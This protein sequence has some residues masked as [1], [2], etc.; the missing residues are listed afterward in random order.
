MAT[1]LVMDDLKVD[2]DEA[3][4]VLRESAE[5]GNI[6]NEELEDEGIKDGD[7]DGD[8]DGTAINKTEEFVEGQ[9]HSPRKKKKRRNNEA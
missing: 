3:R 4:R 7:D 9:Q 8:D 1:L 5:L 2:P 6:V